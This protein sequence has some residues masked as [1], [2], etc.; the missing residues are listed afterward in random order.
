MK[1]PHYPL[2]DSAFII[3]KIL[4]SGKVDAN[5]EI[6]VG[7][8]TTYILAGNKPMHKRTI[9]IREFNGE[10]NFNQATSFALIFGFM[11][12]LLEWYKTNKNWNEGGYFVKK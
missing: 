11:G 6:K 9:T 1:Q 10:I 3:R 5:T 12:D 8:T 4:E 7:D 2:V